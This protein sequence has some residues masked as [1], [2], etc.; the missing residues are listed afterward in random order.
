MFFQQVT[1]ALLWG[2]SFYSTLNNRGYTVYELSLQT[3]LLSQAWTRAELGRA[4]HWGTFSYCPSGLCC[5]IFC[6]W[7]LCVR[8]LLVHVSSVFGSFVPQKLSSFAPLSFT[9]SLC[10]WILGFQTEGP[11]TVPLGGHLPGTTSLSTG[12][13]PR[14]HA[15]PISGHPA[16]S[17]LYCK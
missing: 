15:Q 12:A 4:G 1:S 17:G 8:T 10:C 16:N 13:H 2:R 14:L 11:Q 7:L 5:H 9:T 6:S 3:D